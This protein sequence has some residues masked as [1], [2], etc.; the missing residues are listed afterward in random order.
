M[1]VGP[2]RSTRRRQRMFRRRGH[3]SPT[4]TRDSKVR[5]T[6]SNGRCRLSLDLQS[7]A[8]SQYC[9]GRSALKVILN[10]VA[11]MILYWRIRPRA[12]HLRRLLHEGD[13]N[14]VPR[15]DEDAIQASSTRPHGHRCY[16]S[17]HQRRKAPC[18]RSMKPPENS[19]AFTAS[20]K[21][22]PSRRIWSSVLRRRSPVSSGVK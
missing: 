9:C 21:W 22:P 6:C 8:R 20:R 18:H 7:D 5:P 16:A 12:L 13:I 2:Q 4:R 17:T 3:H 19:T 11:G 1:E 10:A 14:F 15:S